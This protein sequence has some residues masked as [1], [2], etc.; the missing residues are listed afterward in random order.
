MTAKL[1]VGLLFGGKSAEREVSAHSAKSILQHLDPQK[2]DVTLI[3]IDPHGRWYLHDTQRFLEQALSY[4]KFN[5]EQEQNIL[6]LPSETPG[7]LVSTQT[8][9]TLGKLDVILPIMHGTYGEDGCIQGFLK[10]AN[11]PFVGADVLASAVGMD[12]DVAKRLLRDAGIPQARFVTILRSQQADYS[13]ASLSEQLG[14]P[15]FTKPANAGSSVGVHKVRN[16]EEYHHALADGFRFDHKVLVEEFI[17]GREIE[18]A[19]LGNENP[20]VSLPGELIVNHDFYS[21]EAKYLDENGATAEIPARLTPAVTESLQQLAVKT[22]QVLNCEGMARVDFFLRGEDELF[23][24]EINTLPGFTTISMYPKMWAA[25]GMSY[26]EL[27]DRLI[28]L[29]LQRFERDRL[30]QITGPA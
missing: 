23:V 13:F 2:Y 29:A 20:L 25:S 18:C 4:K 8:Q 12:K 22:F 17:Q 19:V 30:L 15:F 3:G 21:F 11:L 26:S 28:Q 27:L 16:P 24:N 5:L 6:L 14:L 1:R 7:K 10:M 9:E